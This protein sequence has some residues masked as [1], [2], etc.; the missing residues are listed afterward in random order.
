M[1]N[2]ALKSDRLVLLTGATGYVGGRLLSVLL[3]QGV[4][5]RCL[6]RR[7]EILRARADR[8]VEIMAGDVMD[9]E[10]LSKALV[11]A[12]TAYYLI[13]SMGSP[14]SFEVRDRQGAENFAKAAAANHVRRIIYLGGLGNEQEALSP[15][16]RSRHEVGD[17]LRSSGVPV[18][19][20]R[21]SIILGSGSLSFELIR[22]LV[23]RL[24]IMITP[25][26]VRVPSQPIAITDVL[27]YLLA[28][29]DLPASESRIFEI[30]G[31]DQVTY[32]DLMREYARQRGLTRWLIPVPVLT[33]W[34]SSL[35]LGLVT[36]VFARI[37]RKL[38]ESIRHST[39]VRD[40]TA[41]Q[42]FPIQ[43]VGVRQAIADALRNEDDEI[44]R[45]RWSDALS[46]SGE[47]KNWFGIK[48]GPR[49]IDSRTANVPVS[50]P[51][52]FAPI[53]SIGGKRGWYYANWLWQLR[54]LMD[55]L[56]GG[57]GMRRGRRDR[58]NLRV[59][60]TV[61][62]WRV[63][64]LEPNRRLRLAAEMKL[65]GRAWLEFEVAETAGVSTIRQTAIF[66]PV[67]VFGRAYW[68][69]VYPLHQFVFAG[70]LR[71]IA[72]NAYSAA[73]HYK[74][75][76]PGAGQWVALLV[77]LLL[78]YGTAAIGAAW[79]NTS[80]NDWYR[81]LDKPTWNPPAW[82]FG[83]VWTVLYTTIALAGWL[84]WRRK[85]TRAIRW[86][87][88]VFVLHL[89]LNAMWSCLFFGWRNPGLALA[90]IV[91]LWLSIVVMIVWF[92]PISRSASLL[93]IPYLGW[94][95]F[96]AVLNWSIWRMNT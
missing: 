80:V 57:V 65:P 94:V 7:P 96:A 36:P 4:K 76:S 43:P 60:D 53:Q 27:S 56:V 10:S 89:V 90:E 41:L 42:V 39:I 21:A 20:F 55:L 63:E 44:A 82:V 67:G 26:W 91:G 66:D 25:Q 11:G 31:S 93:L 64:A 83:P 51:A 22:A 46:S 79:T 6:A 1:T 2:A 70:M 5:T 13:H 92:R 23:E 18:I 72:D 8:Q 84:V 29:L 52:A 73:A 88:Y 45:T 28:A 85:D 38:I 78:C 37:G 58:R 77:F 9:F 71:G 14:D 59:G 49:L 40:S 19:E 16:L 54:G 95:S 34:L 3:D 87:L 32:A 47:I 33:P 48:F 24:P 81:S 17:I 69:L 15:H 35:W 86:P 62:C 12:D 30:G 61:D 74:K 50:A 75:P 68:Y